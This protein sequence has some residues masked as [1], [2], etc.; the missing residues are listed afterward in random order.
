MGK[1]SIS[2]MWMAAA[3]RYPLRAVMGMLGLHSP[4]LAGIDRTAAHELPAGCPRV[5]HL[6]KS[7]KVSWSFKLTSL[8]SCHL[9]SLQ[10]MCIVGFA[11]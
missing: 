6:P 10:G 1:V 11:W 7:C 4:P 5:S 3:C 9:H 8:P 2:L